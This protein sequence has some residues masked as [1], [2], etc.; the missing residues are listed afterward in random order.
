MKVVLKK[1]DEM[2]MAIN[3]KAA[4]NSYYVL[5]HCGKDYHR[6]I[7]IACFYLWNTWS[8]DLQWDQNI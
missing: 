8:V 2:E 4:R 6:G 7:S 3:L 1:A 5:L